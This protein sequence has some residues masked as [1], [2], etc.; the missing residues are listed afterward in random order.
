MNVNRGKVKA[1]AII[2]DKYGR[3]VVDESTFLDDEKLRNLQEAV[4]NGRNARNNLP[5]WDR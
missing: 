4:K 2:F 3:I 1:V 5:Q